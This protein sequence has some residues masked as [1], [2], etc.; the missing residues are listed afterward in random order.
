MD[1]QQIDRMGLT[2]EIFHKNEF[3]KSN[4]GYIDRKSPLNQP[5][6]R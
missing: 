1:I 4:S 3:G 6:F 5:D 2:F